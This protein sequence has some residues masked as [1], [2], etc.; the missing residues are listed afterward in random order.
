M[1]I[2]MVNKYQLKQYFIFSSSSFHLHFPKWKHSFT[3]YPTRG[4]TNSLAPGAIQ[5]A[6]WPFVPNISKEHNS[7]AALSWVLII[8]RVLRFFQT[9]HPPIIPKAPI[10]AKILTKYLQAKNRVLPISSLL[11]ITKILLLFLVHQ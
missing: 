1:Y 5:L 10:P 7:G 3:S 9:F 6:S 4:L 8:S 2:K 11:F